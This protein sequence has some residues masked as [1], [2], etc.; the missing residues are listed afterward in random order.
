MTPAMT[1]VIL[2]DINLRNMTLRVPS[3]GLANNQPVISG[4][5]AAGSQSERA[6]LR[7][8]WYVQFWHRNPS[9]NPPGPGPLTRAGTGWDP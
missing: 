7:P 8:A 5:E 2:F 1:H 3:I 6:V 4:H 9:S